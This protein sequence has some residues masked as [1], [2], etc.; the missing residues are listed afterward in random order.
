MFYAG[1]AWRSLVPRRMK[2]SGLDKM[3][4]GL[5]LLGQTR[6]AD[7]SPERAVLDSQRASQQKNNEAI[8]AVSKFLTPKPFS[9]RIVPSVLRFTPP[10]YSQDHRRFGAPIWRGDVDVGWLCRERTAGNGGSC[11]CQIIL[12]TFH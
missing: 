6:K 1:E 7:S 2:L 12:L 9:G 5:S 8:V 4:V 3:E 10:Q 11:P